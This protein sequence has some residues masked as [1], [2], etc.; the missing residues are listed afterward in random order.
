MDQTLPLS[1]Q[2]RPCEGHTSFSPEVGQK[3]EVLLVEDNALIARKTQSVIEG[4]GHKM[5]HVTSG[6]DA[7]DLFTRHQFFDLILMD[8][9]L[10]VKIMDGFEATKQIRKFKFPNPIICFSSNPIEELKI[11]GKK[12]GMTDYVHKK[13]DS[14]PLKKILSQYLSMTPPPKH[15]ELNH[16]RKNSPLEPLSLTAEKV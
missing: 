13:G 10:G 5:T 1:S 8:I 4:L 14:G 9:H 16:Q 12:V 2:K 3:K 7:V 15:R 11:E 6:E